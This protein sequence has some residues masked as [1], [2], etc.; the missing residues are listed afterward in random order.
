MYLE[1]RLPFLRIDDLQAELY[2]GDVRRGDEVAA[3]DL[4]PQPDVLAEELVI[5]QVFHFRP[6][7]GNKKMCQS[8]KIKGFGYGATMSISILFYRRFLKTIL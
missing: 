5:Q 8:N 3:H 4:Q 6:G 7:F 1:V 2:L